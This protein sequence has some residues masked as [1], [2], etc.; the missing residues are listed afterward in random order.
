MH[1]PLFHKNLSQKTLT[2]ERMFDA[3]RSRV[4]AA[5]T[6]SELLDQWWAPK[7]WK[8]I[9]KSFDFREGGAWHY[10]MQG[11]DGITAWGWAAY[12]SI[13]PEQHFALQ[14]GFCDEAGNKDSSLPSTHWNIEFKEEGEATRVIATLTFASEA[15]MEKIIAMGFEEGFSMG[16]GNLDELL[17]G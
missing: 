14:D 15:D 1:K 7:P 8:S 2:V 11:P 5:W 12:E 16:L 13:T 9:T 10:G 17:A 4:W 3:P 6:K